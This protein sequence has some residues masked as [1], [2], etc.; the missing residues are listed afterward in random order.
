MR[1]ALVGQWLRAAHADPVHRPTA[2]RYAIG[3]TINQVGWVIFGF[4]PATSFSW[5]I[6]IGAGAARRLVPIL[7][8]RE[9]ANHLAS[10][11]YCR[12]LR[13]VHHHRSWRGGAGNFPGNSGS[14]RITFVRWRTRG[15]CHWRD[16]HALYDLVDLFRIYNAPGVLTRLRNAFLWGYGH[17]LLWGCHRGN[18]HRYCRLHRLCNRPLRVVPHSGTARHG[19]SSSALPHLPLELS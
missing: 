3:T 12:A 19:D 16:W 9:V 13:R 8:E 4:V 5:P 7:A 15:H 2:L 1:L 14:G 11:A 17:A 18:W 10:A 6:F